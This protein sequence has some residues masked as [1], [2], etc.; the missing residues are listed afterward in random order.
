MAIHTSGVYN[1]PP[2]SAN[3]HGTRITQAVFNNLMAW[4]NA[5]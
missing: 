1:G 3:N 2:F 4:R 5:P